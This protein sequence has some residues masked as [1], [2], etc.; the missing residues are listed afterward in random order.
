MSRP[1]DQRFGRLLR[2]QRVA[3][4]LSQEELAE[5]AQLSRRTITNLERGVTTPYRETVVRLAD[6]L[7]L[8]ESDRAELENA[9][10]RA[11]TPVAITLGEAV[12]SGSPITAGVD[13]LV[14][15]KLTI[16]PARSTL[17]PRPHLLER[18]QVGLRGALT[19]LS[20]PA[21]S[22]KTTLL[23]AWRA[24]PEG[25]V[26]PLAWVALDEEDNDPRR[27]WRYVLTALDSA[28]PG[29]GTA[30]LE[31]LQSSDAPSLEA[32]LT[33]LVNGLAEQRKDVV[34]ILDD[35]H[36]IEADAI[37]RML[38]HLLEHPPSCLH[39][40][41]ATRAD[42]LL[43]LARLR[44][45]GSVTELRA[46]D[47]RFTVDDTGAFLNTVMGVSLSSEEVAALATR[48]E[49][50][51]AGLQL[52]GLS[53]QG[54][55]AEDTARF[56]AEF[57]GSHRYIVDYLLD[58]VL[59]RQPE[60]VQR[61][62]LHT[63]ILGRLCAPLCAALLEGEDPPDERIAAKPETGIAGS[64]EMLEWLERHNL[65]LIALD[66]ERR[67]YR[68]H[69]LFADAVRQRQR[70][71]AA[72]PEASVLHRRA[73]GWFAQQDLVDEAITHALAGGDFDAAAALLPRATRRMGPHG[74]LQG[75]SA[76]HAALPEALLRARPQLALGYAWILLDFRDFRRAKEYLHH[77]DVALQTSQEAYPAHE[78]EAIHAA[79]AADRALIAV[80]QGDAAGA[81]VQ[82]Q[83]VLSGLEDAGGRTRSGT[84][85]AARSITGI[86][87]GLAHLSRG[88]MSEAVEAFR[89][90]AGANHAP[91]QALLP[92]LATVGEACAHRLAGNL[93]LA[94]STYERA[95]PWSV[96]S[97]QTSV[98]A[99]SLHTGVADILRERNELDA[100]RER[101]AQ[102][103]SL[104]PE[105]GATGAERWIEWQVCNLLVLAR[106]KQ[107]QG[108]LD[109]ALTDVHEA[110]HHL[111]GSGDSTIAAIL[112]AF[113]AQ[114]HL[115]Q[116]NLDPAVRW[117][118]SAAGQVRLRIGLTP[119]V[120][121]YLT[122]YLELTPIQ[123]LI[124]QGRAGRDP[125]AIHRALALLG[126][127]QE[128]AGWLEMVWL[129]S[130]ALVLEALAHQALGEMSA[131]R[132]VL[133]NALVLAEPG[134][135]VRLF[136]DEGSPIADLLRER[137]TNGTTSTFAAVVLAALESRPDR[138][139]P[140]TMREQDGTSL[141]PPL[142]EPLTPRERD[143]LRLLAAGQSNPEIARSLSVELNTVK[144]HVKSL[145]GKLDVHSRMDAVRRARELALL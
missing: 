42:P 69:Y 97:A 91:H 27:F 122:E 134:R 13:P 143:V 144:T 50:W 4:G 38:T 49:G 81:M 1:E 41:L 113:Q 59:L 63:C 45:R 112:A 79:I 93:D 32:V 84:G 31:V 44:A 46:A 121:G 123:V 128:K 72:I 47:L 64:Q 77:A 20:A 132:S 139:I 37:H 105:A 9:V 36:V 55:S 140:T 117:L 23:S 67:W 65:F 12:A 80:L 119:P 19:L 125:T 120:F 110:Q 43:P 89:E 100:A 111:A 68:Y 124:A 35:Y 51:V 101:A 5:R 6:A 83:A 25:Q 26:T 127:L 14:A 76:W 30:P 34:L 99:G 131:A 114:L 85:A 48:T 75:L 142:T 133:D 60:E 136:L 126:Q 24:T 57:T 96:E 54:R 61:F 21:G 17:I 29:A 2:A 129:R 28:V 15:T 106:I 18:L 137:R 56:I 22:G 39:V 66:D 108:D 33:A 7:E 94:R 82:A 58:E 71:N 107:A 87:L 88:A 92:F 104:M 145:Y 40:V 62:L 103:I 70:N 11:R 141:S 8:T 74:T 138:D 95:L 90:V 16:P 3:A 52:A 109:G 130:K 116:G 135:W 78:R 53:L 73:S 10:Q 118:R 115:T 102:G 86:A 98:L